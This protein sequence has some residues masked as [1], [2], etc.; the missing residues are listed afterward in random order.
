MTDDHFQKIYAGPQT[1]WYDEMVSCE[2]VAGHFRDFIRARVKGLCL[3]DVGAG[4]G[5]VSRIASPVARQ[6]L[7][8]D[9]NLPMLRTAKSTDPGL[10]IAAGD[11]LHLPI[12]KGWAE[13]IVAGWALGHFVGWFADWRARIG[14]ALDEMNRVTAPAGAQIIVETLGTGFAEPAPPT[15]GLAAY[16]ALL[17]SEYSFVRHT[18]RTD[19]R[20]PDVATGARLVGFFFGDELAQRLIDE[21]SRDLIEWTGVWVRS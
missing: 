16:Y 5:R 12:R 21:D 8:T 1:D 18:L 13:V 6:V 14:Y 11:A 20:F 2:D 7:T 4:T 10:M 19:Y 3:L 15:E 17:E 9:L